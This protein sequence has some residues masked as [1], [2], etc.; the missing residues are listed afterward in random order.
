MINNGGDAV[1]VI[2][3]EKPMTMAADDEHHFV[4]YAQDLES[5]DQNVLRAAGV[6]VL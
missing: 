5:L 1:G 6:T 2:V 3:G 4:H